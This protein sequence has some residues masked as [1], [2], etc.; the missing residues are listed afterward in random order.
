MY[1]YMW[2][3]LLQPRSGQKTKQHQNPALKKKLPKKK[4]HNLIC[5]G[6][7]WGTVKSMYY[8]TQTSHQD[9]I[10]LELQDVTF[11]DRKQNKS[12][13]NHIFLIGKGSEYPAGVDEVFPT[14]SCLPLTLKKSAIIKILM[15]KTALK[16]FIMCLLELL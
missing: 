7:T 4:S 3:V 5:F 15:C 9:V 1:F 13:S 2:K 16:S 12:K 8:I 11:D 14:V 10:L 6:L